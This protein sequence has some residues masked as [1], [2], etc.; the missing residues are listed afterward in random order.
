MRQQHLFRE[1][2][3]NEFGGSL[4]KKGQRKVARP[5]S[6][7]RPIHLVLKAKSANLLLRNRITIQKRA[8]KL[9]R[10]FG[11]KLYAV[12]VQA[13]HIHVALRI[14]SRRM[15]SAWIRSLTGTL[16][17]AIK[18][19]KW[20]LRP[21]TRISRWGKEFRRLAE[22]LDFND[23]EA[24][25]IIGAWRDIEIFKLNFYDDWPCLGSTARKLTKSWGR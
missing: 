8:E 12:A 14:S 2:V 18:G 4:F 20:K 15:Y 17:R 24:E 21:Y 19:L 13:D 16:S 7:K 1:K 3:L 22:Y 11:I 9:G 6:T 23:Q 25:L 5:L 10:K